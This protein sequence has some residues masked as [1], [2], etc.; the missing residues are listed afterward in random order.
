MKVTLYSY[1]LPRKTRKK[2]KINNNHQVTVG[3]DVAHLKQ[4][5]KCMFIVS[6]L[7]FGSGYDIEEL[8]CIRSCG[9]RIHLKMW[10]GS[11]NRYTT[12]PAL[13]ILIW[14]WMSFILGVCNV[15][16]RTRHIVRSFLEGSVWYIFTV[17]I[18]NLF[19]LSVFKRIKASFF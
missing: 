18:Y 13:N 19:L 12:F 11:T 7:I 8:P 17:I 10:L 9:F 2:L 6:G 3:T 16:S 14:L 15:T 5:M 4:N 1:Q